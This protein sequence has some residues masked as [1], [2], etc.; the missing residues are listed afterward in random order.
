MFFFSESGSL[1]GIGMLFFT[2]GVF[3]YLCKL[4]K[5]NPNNIFLNALLWSFLAIML[6][7]Q[8]DAGIT[9][10]FVMRL[11]STYLGIGLSSVAYHRLQTDNHNLTAP[12]RKDDSYENI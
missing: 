6:H 12:E 11:Y 7:G 1:G 9:S 10:K 4:M 8:V 3:L 5:K 2:V